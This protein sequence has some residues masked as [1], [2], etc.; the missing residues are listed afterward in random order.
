MYLPDIPKF[1]SL[2]NSFTM[3]RPETDE[4]W[5]EHVAVPVEQVS[6]DGRR[7]GL[8]SISFWY[9]EDHDLTLEGLF[10]KINAE[11]SSVGQKVNL[12][13]VAAAVAIF[14][15]SNRGSFSGVEQFN[16]FFDCV[17]GSD[18]NQFV[19]VPL[20]KLPDYRF[21]VGPF[22]IGPF[23]PM[24]LAY[25]SKKSGSDY[26]ERYE[27]QLRQMP[28]SVERKFHTV[29]VV[30]WSKLVGV[31][32]A[33]HP[34]KTDFHEAVIRLV[35]Y[36]FA[37]LSSLH[38]KKFFE[39]LHDTQEVAIAL[40]SGW[41]AL[42]PVSDLTGSHQISI[43]QNMDGGKEGFVSPSSCDLTINLGGGHLG[44][45][46]TESYLHEYFGFLASQDCDIHK[47]LRTYCH[48]LALGA[49]HRAAG[50]QA[51]GFLHSVIALDL[52]LGTEGAST[53]SVSTRGAAL[54]HRGV[55]RSYKEV[56][57]ELK[58]IYNARSKYVHEGR[59]PEKRLADST[60][61]LCREVVFCL[62]R[63][64]RE[65]TNKTSAFSER[66]LKDIDFLVAAIDA[67]R[68]ISDDD[69]RR[70]GAWIEGDV[71]HSDFILRLK[72]AQ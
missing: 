8:P 34:S 62:F 28:F 49:E 33:W 70:V 47:S 71:R 52:L 26:F 15:C 54:V 2:L 67:N 57:E 29:K 7:I 1:E 44:I 14:A 65:A 19:L 3:V 31:G 55:G 39:D 48:F 69:L 9:R 37:Q 51:E 12:E 60:E 43:F 58:T 24:R 38:F 42:D 20:L 59:I 56:L 32:G 68:P 40:G 22:N 64:Q 23:D 27:K 16:R 25:Q 30:Q 53:A 72:S 11:L 36:Y 5:R 66:W 45:P 21:N 41:F 63:L 50:R 35:D 46:F 17:V 13:L 4:G 61:T 10:K 6:L 18:L